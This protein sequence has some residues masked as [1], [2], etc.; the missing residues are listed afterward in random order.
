MRISQLVRYLQIGSTL[1]SLPVTPAL[2]DTLLLAARWPAEI[3]CTYTGT[4]NKMNVDVDA[5]ASPPALS[6]SL[7]VR[8]SAVS[9]AHGENGNVEPPPL[10]AE[11]GRE[12]VMRWLQTLRVPSAQAIHLRKAFDACGFGHLV[13]FFLTTADSLLSALASPSVFICILHVY[14]FPILLIFASFFIHT[15]TYSIYLL[16]FR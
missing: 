2:G 9:S 14:V 5:N 12:E 15:R 11:S 3:E 6:E 7:S 8:S 4:R 16:F 10:R 13:F 1:D